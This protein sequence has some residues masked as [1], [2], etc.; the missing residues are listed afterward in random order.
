VPGAPESGDRFG[1]SISGFWHD[2]LNYPWVY[3]GV[4]GE[5][6]GTVQDAGMVVSLNSRGIQSV[7][8]YTDDS[9]GGNAERGDKFGASVQ[10]T[11]LSSGANPIT[12]LVVI[13]IPGENGYGVVKLAS[14]VQ[15]TWRQAVLDG[16]E[17]GD[18]YGSSVRSAR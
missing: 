6:I 4:P 1:A 18:G 8:S 9:L 3:V 13:G 17:A 12:Y 7:P 5:D 14:P 15:T 10:A 16:S 2:I 11:L